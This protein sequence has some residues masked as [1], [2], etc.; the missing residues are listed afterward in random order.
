M[1]MKQFSNDLEYRLV[2]DDGHINGYERWNPTTQTWQTSGFGV[3][4][5]DGVIKHDRKD[6][7]TGFKDAHGEKIFENDII[8]WTIKN[9]KGAEFE[10][11]LP[12]EW[13]AS[14]AKFRPSSL[15]LEDVKVAGT[16]YKNADLIKNHVPPNKD[17]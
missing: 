9:T 8:Q 4:F 12:V 16:I 6:R 7:F 5:T 1:K 13:V 3:H 17:N 14:K 15:L 10:L 2:G 11:F